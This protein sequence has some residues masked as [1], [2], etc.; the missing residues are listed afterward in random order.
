MDYVSYT[1]LRQNL[2]KH[3]DKVCDDRAPLVV[4]RRNAG[5]VVVLSLAD[6]ESLEE[7]LYL[8]SDPENAEHLRKS[9]ADANAGKLIAHDLSE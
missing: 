7:T 8:L 4:T 3:L 6:Y 1:E 5:A 9:I 2:K